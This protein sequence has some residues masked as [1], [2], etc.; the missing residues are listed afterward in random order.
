MMMAIKRKQR[1]LVIVERKLVQNRGHHHTQITALRT[2]LPDYKTA[3]ITGEAYDGFLGTP[4]ATLAISAPKGSKLRSRLKYGNPLERL[5][6]LL[7][8]LRKD[9]L[10]NMPVSVY[11]QRLAEIVTNLE[12]DQSDVIIVPTADLD[13][14][15]SSVDLHCILGDAA[16]RIILRFL[17]TEL[18]DRN[19]RIRSARLREA[20][21]KLPHGI[22]LFTE[23]EELAD[24]LRRE[25]NIP[26]IGG[27]YLPC[28]LPIGEAPEERASNDRFRIGV[29]GDPRPEKGSS[30]IPGITT[31]L[32]QKAAAGPATQLEVVVQ[33]G[34]ADFQEHGVYS[35]L[36]EYQASGGVVVVS[37]RDNHLSPQEFRR[38]FASVD[39]ILL[40]YDASVYNLQGS[41]VLQ[42]AVAARKPIIYTKGMS[43]MSFLDH[44]NGVAAET[45]EDFAEAIMR[46]ASDPTAFREGTARAAAYLQHVLA[47]NPFLRTINAT[48]Q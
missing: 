21:A 8:L 41:G 46:V 29:F 15:E 12:L 25:F 7:A 4:A 20:R 33:G 17:N 11:G 10:F 27:F 34:T 19:D 48:R 2:M 36:A 35:A 30:R 5:S 40:P 23:T 1:T 13:T 18:G 16:P 24:H 22:L 28:S 37:P 14:L 44:G 32:A 42:D 6:A 39:T 47:A 45:D 43:M 3:L 26:I 38:L 9:L 31:A